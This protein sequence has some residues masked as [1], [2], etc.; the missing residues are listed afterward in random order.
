MINIDF[1][2]A[3]V[4]VA[5]FAFGVGAY[6]CLHNVT[7][8]PKSLRTWRIVI[9]GGC[10]LSLIGSLLG[11]ARMVTGWHPLSGDVCMLLVVGGGLVDLVGTAMCLSAAPDNE[12]HDKRASWPWPQ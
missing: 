10:V 11:L 1:E 9:A 5:I 4:S 6:M 7:A 3:V 12:P 2:V 8:A